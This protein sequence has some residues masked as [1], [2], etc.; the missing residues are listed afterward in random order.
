[1]K[2]KITRAE[3]RRE[4]RGLFL[5]DDYSLIGKI[6]RSINL[7]DVSC[8]SIKNQKRILK[9][10]NNLLEVDNILNKIQDEDK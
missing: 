9:M 1:M 2:S 8:I 10:K 5:N 7:V 6:L 3:E 4:L